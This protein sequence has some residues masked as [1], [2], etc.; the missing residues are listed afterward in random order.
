[1]IFVDAN[2]FVRFLLGEDSQQGR[3]EKRVFDLGSSGEEQLIGSTVVFFEVYWVLHSYYELKKE[4]LKDALTR[5]LALKFVR[6]EERD[7]L[8]EAVTMLPNTNYDL[9]DAYHLV[10]A[11]KMGVEQ[12]LIF[13]GWI[14]GEDVRISY[15]VSDVVLMPSICFD[16]FGRVNI[17]AMAAHKPVI[18]TCYGGTPEIVID[19]VTG[20]IVNPRYPEEIAEKALDLL[21]NPE[22]A[23]KF[24][25]AG[26][27]R[28]VVEFNQQD[29]VR[30]Y[31]AVYETLLKERG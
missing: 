10:W 17:E 30:E 12:H 9:E 25:K 16:A 27:E 5:V 3:E 14:W 13:T 19:G 26:Y 23:Q 4:K 1:M 18:G 7:L 31:I 15:A 24:G 6:F 2:Y 8:E 22:K 28:V 11:K 29:K 20:Y 21:Q